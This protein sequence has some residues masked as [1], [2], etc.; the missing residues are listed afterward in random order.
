[1][2]DA[3]LDLRFATAGDAA[4]VALML[5][6]MDAHYRPGAVLPTAETYRR[7]AEATLV[8]REGTRFALCFAGGVPVG[9]ACIGVL[10]PG[11]D[12]QGLV[13][14]K[15]LFVAERARG[16]GVGRAL[17]GF[18]ARFALASGLGRIDLTT[19]ADNAGARRLYTRLGGGASDKVFF[20]FRADALARLAEEPGPGAVEAGAAGSGAD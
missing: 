3:A 1:M 14:L 10:R 15:D 6:E 17:M 5:R 16:R 12:L 19:D 2:P 4:A 13:F 9:I 20:T 7:V 11:R 8:E 18:L